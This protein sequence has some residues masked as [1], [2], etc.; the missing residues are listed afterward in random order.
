VKQARIALVTSVTLFVLTGSFLAACSGIQERT[1]PTEPASTPLSMSPRGDMLYHCLRQKGWD[2]EIEWDGG[3][4]ADSE[5]IP[6]AQE[7]IYSADSADCLAQ[8]ETVFAVDFAGKRALYEAEVK[9]RDCL[10]LNGYDIPEAPTEQVYVDNYDV[11]LWMAWSY[12][13]LR[14]MDEA[15]YRAL[16][17]L[18]PQ[19][20]WSAGAND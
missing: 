10:I 7:P 14:N 17:T 20:Q 19:P 3:V 8:V 9:T 12:V 2:V 11:D 6:I 5:S 13:N 1:E 15:S 4:I 16:N 18:C